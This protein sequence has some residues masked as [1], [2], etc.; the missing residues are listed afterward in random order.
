MTRRVSFAA[1]ALFLSLG[2][3][4][5][6]PPPDAGRD[7]GRDAGPSRCTFDAGPPEAIPEP[8]VYTPRWAFEPWISKDISDRDDSY[9]FVQGFLDRGIP[10]GVLVIDSPWDV[11]YTTFTP[12]ESRYPDFAGM[13]RDMHALDIRVVMW[14]T[15]MVNT[16]SFDAETGGDSYRG[17]SP[18]Y[19]EGCE[20]GFFVEDC[21]QYMWWKG[22]GSGVDFF[23]PGARAWWHRLQDALLDMGIDGWKLDFGESY[24]EE[25]DP[26]RTFEGLQSHQAYSEAYYRDFLAYGRHRRGRELVTMVRPWDVS[27]DRRARF[28]ARPEHAPV[29]WVGDNT[30]D[31]RGLLDA[32][33]HIFRSADA[34]YVVVG[35][36]IG[37]YLDRDDQDLIRT[38]P[39][40]LEVFQ[41][42]VALGAMTPFMQLHG[43]ANLEPWALPEGADQTVELY[44]YWATL[45]HAMVDFWYSLTQ[46]AYASGGVILHPVG[47][48]PEWPGDYRYVVGEHFLVAPILEAGGIRDVALPSGARWY[49]WWAPGAAPLEGGTTIVGYDASAPG[50]I[51]LFVREGAIVPVVVDSDVN[52][53][54]TAASAG[55]QT[56][57]VWPSARETSFRLHEVDDVV[58]TIRASTST[59]T[60]SRVRRPT[61]LRVRRDTPPSAVRASDAG[62]LVAHPDRAAFDAAEEG[63]LYDAADRWLW[64]KVRPAGDLF[65]ILID[66]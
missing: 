32:L 56:I 60:L 17:E 39:F 24:M 52:G 40:D 61:I 8:E 21:K 25:D 22:F 9:A 13:V 10:T 14:T 19:D 53:L 1:L 58:T 66:D 28:H 49:D 16:S 34:G 26:M 59:I 7:A 42:W 27:Y 46:E 6:A 38:I 33:D 41:R 55:H 54:G 11:H 43:R 36:D 15:Q 12:R 50:R 57:L 5:V 51:P 65:T 47:S 37:G 64:V 4:T 63:M 30:R 44:R 23:H 62:S 29:A 18:N 2:C 48:E 3:N 31:W 45:H 20:C 35:S